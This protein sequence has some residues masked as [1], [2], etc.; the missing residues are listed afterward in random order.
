M[1]HIIPISGKDSLAT[2]LVQIARAPEINYE[3]MFN[4][5][6][7]ELPEVFVWIKKVETYL[8]KPIVQ[9]GDSLRDILEFEYNWFLPSGQARWCTRRTKIEP[10]EKY[11]GKS[12]CM[13]YY[14]IRADENRGG[15]VNTAFPNITPVYPLKEMGIGI[16]TVYEINHNAGLKP[17]AFRWLSVYEEVCRIVGQAYITETFTEW[18]IDQLFAWRSRTN[19]ANCYNQRQYEWVGLHE[20]HPVIF[21]GYEK[22]EHNIS[23]YFFVGKDK[24]LTWIVANSERIKRARVKAIIKFIERT[25]QLV[26]PFNENND[27]DF[28]DFLQITSCGLLCGK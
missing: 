5:T 9:I 2:A 6:G 1:R 12:D 22:W 14:G 27:D 16:S 28:V 8:G 23:E 4:P 19:C 18:E 26:I 17:P 20:H 11:I 10:M 21:W 3:F 24:P 25:K 7:E 13:V 15:Y